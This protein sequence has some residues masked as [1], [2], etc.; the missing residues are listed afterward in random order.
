MASHV[1]T[2]FFAHTRR[3]RRT[4]DLV[5]IIFTVVL[6]VQTLVS[7]YI[8]S[9]KLQSGYYNVK[10]TLSITNVINT[11]DGVRFQHQEKVIQN[12]ASNLYLIPQRDTALT[13][14]NISF[15]ND[16][17]SLRAIANIST[18][19]ILNM[20]GV[21]SE[22]KPRY[23][24]RYMKGISLQRSKS[25]TLS[26]VNVKKAN[27]PKQRKLNMKVVAETKN[28]TTSLRFFRRKVYKPPL[29]CVLY[30]KVFVDMVPLP[31]DGVQ[32]LDNVELTYDRRLLPD[33]AFVFFHVRGR[34]G[35]PSR[36]PR[37][38]RWVL[39]TQE[40]PTNENYKYWKNKLLFNFTAHY[41]HLADIWSPYGWCERITSPL[42][43]ETTQPSVTHK[44]KL[45]AWAVSNCNTKSY[46]EIYAE[47]LKEHIHVDTYGKCGQLQASNEVFMRNLRDYK[48]YLSFEN[49]LCTEYNTEKVF[50]YLA[51]PKLYVIPVVLGLSHEDALPKGSYIDIRNF[52]S[53]LEL[54]KYLLYLDANQTAFLEYFYWRKHFK[55]H[56]SR[57]DRHLKL[58]RGIQSVINVTRTVSSKHVQ[59]VY[60]KMNCI[61]A[62][63]YYRNITL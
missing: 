36:R 15:H 48:F 17:Q 32:V 28:D 27:K 62:G 22:V 10:S 45:V 26:N 31:S 54:A 55:C 5:I 61:P 4:I 56:G 44:N 57:Y 21:Q 29:L 34:D 35:F 41:S 2:C 40:S 9:D 24:F 47:K 23:T 43:E 42:G 20:T 14:V 49:S 59:K 58:I 19:F 30:S 46:R 38:Q 52:E 33:A 39:Y 11:I 37:E 50:L 60:S 1:Y 63:Q 18:D 8:R 6:I 25:Q 16:D 13:T 51:E 53:P 12:K 3:S 7:R